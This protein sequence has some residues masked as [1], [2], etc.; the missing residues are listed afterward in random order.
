MLRITFIAG[1]AILLIALIATIG[2]KVIALGQNGSWG[3]SPLTDYSRGIDGY[4]SNPANLKVI[5]PS[6]LGFI[7]IWVV[8]L[9][10]LVKR[11]PAWERLWVKTLM[12]GCSFMMVFFLVLAIVGCLANFTSGLVQE[13]A[14]KLAGFMSSPL[15]ME[16]SLF[17]IGLTLLFCYNAIRRKLDGDDFVEMEIED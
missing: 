16:A 9:L 1:Y 4:I 14:A 15:F 11:S 10:Y 7:A 5:I 13:T 2:V 8:A 17:F 3:E 6:I 12:V